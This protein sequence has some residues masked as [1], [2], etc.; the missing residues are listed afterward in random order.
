[1]GMPTGSI[2]ANIGNVAKM[3]IETKTIQVLRKM[4]VCKRGLIAFHRVLLKRL[5]PV[6]L[7]L[8]SSL[9]ALCVLLRCTPPLSG[10]Q[11]L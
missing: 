5:H 3:R 4:Y 1:M 9:F 7:S 11:S 8:L 6:P 2:G 10:V